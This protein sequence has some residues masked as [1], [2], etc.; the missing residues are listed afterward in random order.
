MVVLLEI[1]VAVAVIY[2]ITKVTLKILD[3]RKELMKL[4]E[5]RIARLESA[6]TAKDVAQELLLDKEM[7]K[8]VCAQLKAKLDDEESQ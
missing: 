6:A 5:E 1:A 2:G 7:A 4:R 3:N 8:D